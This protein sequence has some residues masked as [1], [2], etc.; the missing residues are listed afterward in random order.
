[1][2]SLLTTAAT[3]PSYVDFQEHRRTRKLANRPKNAAAQIWKCSWTYAKLVVGLWS[4]STA[5]AQP[6]RD[7]VAFML[8]FCVPVSYSRTIIMFVGIRYK[9][10]RV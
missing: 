7:K 5:C 6:R 2:L 8:D 10:L 9:H 1:V 4:V 3:R